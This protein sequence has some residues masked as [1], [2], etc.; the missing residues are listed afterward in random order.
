MFD[1]NPVHSQSF[2]LSTFIKIFFSRVINL[3]LTSLAQDRT[4]SIWALGFICT[5]LHTNYGPYCQDLGPIFSQYFLRAWLRRCVY[6][7]C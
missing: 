6:F 1:Q 7:S 2:S 3:L 5:D 4:A